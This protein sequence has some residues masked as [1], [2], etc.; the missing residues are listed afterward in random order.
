MGARVVGLL[1]ARAPRLD[2]A[3][4]KIT[5]KGGGLVLLDGSLMRTRRRTG[6]DN[7]KYCSS[8]RACHGLLVVA[9][10][11]D[12]GRPGRAFP[13]PAVKEADR[14]DTVTYHATLSTNSAPS[15]CTYSLWSSGTSAPTEP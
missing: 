9:L 14:G 11:D 3:L 6:A 1:A 15:G 13:S 4:R 12:R 8:K 5:R 2:R 7:R 10:T